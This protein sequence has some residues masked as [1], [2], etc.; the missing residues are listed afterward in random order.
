M[1]LTK[2]CLLMI[3]GA[4]VWMGAEYQENKKNPARTRVAAEAELQSASGTLVNARVVDFKTEKGVLANHY[5]E[6]DIEGTAG[7]KTVRLAEPHNEKMLE[8]LGGKQVIAKYD[9]IDNRYVYSLDADGR[10]VV[11]Y[12]DSADYKAKLAKSNS[13]GYTLGWIVLALGLAGLW[14]DR[15]KAS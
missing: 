5:T 12:R 3:A 7:I 13:G 14:L 4:L 15:R 2:I 9:E 1:S 8:G 10:E 11:A 6:L